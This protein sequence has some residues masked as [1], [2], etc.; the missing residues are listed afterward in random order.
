MALDSGCQLPG[1]SLPGI[2]QLWS[3][4]LCASGVSQVPANHATHPGL[5][6]AK[7]PLCL[8]GLA[9]D[10]E[11]ECEEERGSHLPGRMSESEVSHLPGSSCVSGSLGLSSFLLSAIRGDSL[12]SF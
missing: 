1:R 3:F 10:R 7:A 9:G 2:C 6:L 11:C 12:H 4:E 8:V 5:K